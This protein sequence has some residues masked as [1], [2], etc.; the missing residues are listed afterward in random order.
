M[1]LELSMNDEGDD[2]LTKRQYAHTNT[3]PTNTPATIATATTTDISIAANKG[4]NFRK[5]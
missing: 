5:C 4:D 1:K 2:Q 3:H